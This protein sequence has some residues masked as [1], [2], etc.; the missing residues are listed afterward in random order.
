MI[1]YYRPPDSIAYRDGHYWP[2]GFP[3][4]EDKS[5]VRSTT[6]LDAA[7]IAFQIS[8]TEQQ[9][10]RARE[11][12]VFK[13]YAPMAVSTKKIG[14]TIEQFE[15]QTGLN[16]DGT[17]ALINQ[18]VAELGFEAHGQKV[19]LRWYCDHE[20]VQSQC[21]SQVAHARKEEHARK[22]AEALNAKFPK[23]EGFDQ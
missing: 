16:L 12:G 8:Y 5:E 4:P 11:L 23:G 15:R 19:F 18:P 21:L 13:V 22:I 10:L 7:G 17:A 1:Y 6:Y 3:S 2:C 9:M 20:E 14:P